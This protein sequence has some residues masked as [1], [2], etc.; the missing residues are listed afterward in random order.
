MSIK[1]N[2]PDPT[3]AFDIFAVLISSKSLTNLS[4]FITY[5]V[6]YYY[7]YFNLRISSKF[8]VNKSN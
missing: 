6:Y 8:D 5:I 3:Q 7:Y 1:S 4:H 2:S